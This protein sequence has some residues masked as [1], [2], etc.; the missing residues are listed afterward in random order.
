MAWFEAGKGYGDLLIYVQPGARMTAIAGV[1]AGRIKVRVAAK[2]QD[3]K[4]NDAL[5]DALAAWLDVPP[6]LLSLESGHHSRQKRVRCGLDP[7]DL[8]PRLKRLVS[9][10]F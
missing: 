8:E 4:A 10:E 5:L 6:R 2:P 1:H 3:G 7:E 9:R